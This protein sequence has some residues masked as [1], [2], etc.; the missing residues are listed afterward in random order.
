MKVLGG[1]VGEGNQACVEMHIGEG[2][3]RTVVQVGTSEM[4]NIRSV[5]VRSS[6][7]RFCLGLQRTTPPFG[8]YHVVRRYCVSRISGILTRLL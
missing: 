4:C 8:R 6:K 1:R 5:V 7:S 3:R 2:E